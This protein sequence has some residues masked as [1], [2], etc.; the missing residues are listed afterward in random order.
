M[1]HTA[2]KTGD[3]RKAIGN[4]A[5]EKMELEQNLRRQLEDIKKQRQAIEEQILSEIEKESSEKAVLE[6]Q[7]QRKLLDRMEKRVMMEMQM[8]QLDV[9]EENRLLTRTP[10]SMCINPISTPGQKAKED[11]STETSVSSKFQSGAH[12]RFEEPKLKDDNSTVTNLSLSTASSPTPKVVMFKLNKSALRGNSSKSKALPR[13]YRLLTITMSQPGTLGLEIEE[14]DDAVSSACV[15]RVVPG[16]LGDASGVKKG[17]VLCHADSDIEFSYHE[18]CRLAQSGM[19]P[20]RFNVRRVE[21]QP[22]VESSVP[23][24][25]VTIVATESNASIEGHIEVQLTPAQ[26][27][28]KSEHGISS[29]DDSEKVKNEDFGSILEPGTNLAL[30][31]APLSEESNDVLEDDGEEVEK[32]DYGSRVEPETNLALESVPL[33]EASNDVLEDDGKKVENENYGSSSEHETN[34]ALESVPLSEESND[35][36]EDDGEIVENDDYGSRVEP[37]TNLFLES[38]P[39]SETSNAVQFKSAKGDQSKTIRSLAEAMPGFM[40]EKDVAKIVNKI[41]QYISGNDEEK[42]RGINVKGAEHKNEE[43]L[44]SQNSTLDNASQVVDEINV[45]KLVND[46]KQI[47]N[48][49]KS[50]LSDGQVQRD[51]GN[52]SQEPVVNTHP[53][54]ILPDSVKASGTEKC[55]SKENPVLTREE[56]VK[57]AMKLL[58]SMGYTKSEVTIKTKATAMKEYAKTADTSLMPSLLLLSGELESKSTI[59]T[60]SAEEKGGKICVEVVIP[61]QRRNGVNEA[62]V[63]LSSE[64]SLQSKEVKGRHCSAHGKRTKKEKGKQKKSSKEKRQSSRGQGNKKEKRKRKSSKRVKENPIVDIQPE[65]KIVQ[66]ELNVL[67]KGALDKEDKENSG[68]KFCIPRETNNA[69]ALSPSNR[70]LPPNHVSVGSKQSSPPDNCKSPVYHSPKA[71]VTNSKSLLKKRLGKEMTIIVS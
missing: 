68:H 37:E 23:G 24:R 31:C 17:D 54:E 52:E 36:L 40:T 1:N 28:F 66:E 60:A 32:E 65:A 6:A 58:E 30:K 43:P 5:R 20:L 64:K 8:G 12:V 57:E 34:L 41:N 42:A 49:S 63:N 29:E 47:R 59:P 61:S 55:V 39:S 22:Q 35:V 13:A 56:E 16:S 45:M 51:I 9:V 25:K 11:L 50:A 69:S 7:L 15:A 62:A 2:P 18:F 67:I 33:S 48:T 38:V 53:E 70:V 44:T 21:A 14:G 46:F 10:K 4:V 71:Q 27:D 3:L 19:R 26:E